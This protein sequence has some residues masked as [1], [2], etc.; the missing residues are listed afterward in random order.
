MK[1]AGVGT[2]LALVA[3]AL[4]ASVG[5]GGCEAIVSNNV[6]AYCSMT[7]YVNPGTGSCPAGQ[8]CEGAGCVACLPKGDDP[9]DG[10]D[11]DC[12]GVIDDGPKSDHDG[13]GYTN[14]GNPSDLADTLDCNDDDKTIHP[15]GH[16]ICNGKDDN[17]DGIIDNP[18]GT[19]AVC[20]SGETCVPEPPPGQCVSNE[21]VC[22]SCATSN[23]PG[24]C[25]SPN[26]CD[27]TTNQCVQPASQDAGQTGCT[28]SLQCSTGICAT[29][30]ELGSGQP[31][32]CTTPCCTSADC[33]SLGSGYVCYGPGTGGNYCVSAAALGRTPPATCCSDS[34]CTGGT[35]CVATASSTSVATFTCT[36][37]PGTKGTNA[38]CKTNADCA[39]GY[40]AGYTAT[41]G[42]GETETLYA[43]AQPCC[44]S[45]QCG[46]LDDNQ[47]VCTDDYYPPPTPGG[48]TPT[49]GP[50]IPVCDLPQEGTG[51]NNTAPTGQVGDACTKPTDCYSNQ[52]LVLGGASYCS[53]V[54]CVDSDCATTGW[55]CRPT[56]VSTGT[57][58]RCVPST[59]T[60]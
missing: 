1:I 21:T 8:F 54:C 25:A 33:T 22:V 44:S 3:L 42:F 6:S 36:A 56:P 45:K 35:A 2:C 11:N 53:D 46:S 31:S 59:S 14:C 38:T 50:V 30:T 58:L 52:C 13:D 18:T 29:S 60:E 43:C 26:V 39:S 15:K 4:V 24:C 32:V 23:T 49:S 37:A 48:A 57:F 5:A 16:E 40:C 7:P 10:Y 34:D 28:S 51:A 55:V 47:L 41:N 9:C 12:D 17:C 27:P 19:Y 20:P